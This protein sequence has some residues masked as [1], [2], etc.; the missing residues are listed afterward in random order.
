VAQG[1]RSGKGDE[2]RVVDDAFFVFIDVRSGSI[3]V[4]SV[5]LTLKASMEP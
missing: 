2:K 5:K 4:K 3:D 1:E